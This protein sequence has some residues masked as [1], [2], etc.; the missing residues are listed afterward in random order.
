MQGSKSISSYGTID[1]ASSPWYGVCIPGTAYENEIEG[2]EYYRVFAMQRYQVV[3]EEQFDLMKA[4]GANVVRIYLNRWAW[5][6]NAPAGLNREPYKQFIEKVA[7]WCYGRGL[8]VIWSAHVYSRWGRNW[9]FPQ[10]GEFLL[11][12]QIEMPF[13]PTW[14]GTWADYIQWLVEI[15]SNPKLRRVMCALHIFNE[16][17]WADDWPGGPVQ[18]ELENKWNDFSRQAIIAVR[19]VVPELPILWQPSPFWIFDICFRKPLNLPNIIYHAVWYCWVPD[20]YTRDWEID[21]I[22]RAY[23][24]GRYDE[25][26]Q[27]MIQY[28]YDRRFFE[29]QDKGEDVFFGEIGTDP[30]CQEAYWD[31]WM[32]DFYDIC[33]ERRIGFVQHAFLYTP[34]KIPEP[35]AWYMWGMLESDF[36]SLNEVG[37]LWRTNMSNTP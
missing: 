28:F 35:V 3:C 25:G 10:K 33:Y 30:Y 18:D 17:P 21:W 6:N 31:R 11:T 15:V 14:T 1:Y 2:E 27:K 5:G 13:E 34:P 32:Q 29:L 19:A 4:C 9:G 12:G 23:A 16:P 24:E 7:D 8:N 26:K 22:A 37:Q 36:K 20:P